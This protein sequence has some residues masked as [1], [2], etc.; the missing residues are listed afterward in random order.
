VASVLALAVALGGGTAFAAS[1]FRITSVKQIKPSVVKK[2][3]GHK[4][5]KGAT[6]APGKNGA[7]AGYTA[8]AT[9]TVL[10]NHASLAILHKTLPAGSYIVHADI[11]VYAQQGSSQ[12]GA[13][14]QCTLQ[15]G[16]GNQTEAY[17][18]PYNPRD[19]DVTQGALAFDV[20]T[21]STASITESLT[22]TDY[23]G[24]NGAQN[25]D[26]GTVDVA[27]SIT[28]VRTSANS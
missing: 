24:A 16:T 28:A 4:G 9:S 12:A 19:D 10:T 23:S 3:R 6:G 17:S 11:S 13:A 20:G 27:G 18:A 22:C 7:V 26:L 25:G 2:L 1:H 15:G 21:S 5:P 8:T 14:I